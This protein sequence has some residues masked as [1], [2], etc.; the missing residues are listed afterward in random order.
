VRSFK[1]NNLVIYLDDDLLGGIAGVTLN[2]IS[3]KNV[4]FVDL[5]FVDLD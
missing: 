2:Q 4:T 1:G 5:A 3:R